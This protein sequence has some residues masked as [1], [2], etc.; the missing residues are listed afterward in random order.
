MDHQDHIFCVLLQLQMHN[1]VHLI[2]ELNQ[3]N[4]KMVIILLLLFH[5]VHMHVLYVHKLVFNYVQIN[6]FYKE[7]M[8]LLYQLQIF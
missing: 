5:L 3:F 7:L 4:V 8:P 6:Y 1:I 2:L